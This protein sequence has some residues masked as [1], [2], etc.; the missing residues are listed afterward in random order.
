MSTLLSQNIQKVPPNY[1]MPEDKRP[2]GDIAAPVCKDIPV[3]DLSQ[4]DGLNRGD[5][6]QQIMKANMDL[7]M[8]QVHPFF[9]HIEIEVFWYHILKPHSFVLSSLL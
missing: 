3:I 6:I 5:L 8:F 4:L 7:G 2:G 9:M 1:V